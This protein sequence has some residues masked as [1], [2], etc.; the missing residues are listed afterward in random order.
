MAFRVRKPKENR[1][2]D[3]FVSSLCVREKGTEWNLYFRRWAFSFLFGV[4]RLRLGLEQHALLLYS[5][6]MV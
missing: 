1:G 6:L 2:V 5:T 3:P 4:L